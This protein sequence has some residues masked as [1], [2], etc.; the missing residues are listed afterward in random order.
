MVGL[1]STVVVLIALGENLRRFNAFPWDLVGNTQFRPRNPADLC[2]APLGLFGRFGWVSASRVPVEAWEAVLANARSNKSGFKWPQYR[3][4]PEKL[5]VREPSGSRLG[6]GYRIVAG[7]R[8][9]GE[10]ARE[11]HYRLAL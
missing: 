6:L 11:E 10:E 4:K 8:E 2:A 9:G 7:S 1:Q 5:A 3:A